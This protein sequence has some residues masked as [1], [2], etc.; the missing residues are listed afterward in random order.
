MRESARRLGLKMPFK[1]VFLR[2]F[3]DERELEI[4]ASNGAGA[5]R[6][7]Q[8][9]PIAAMS[10]GPGPKRQE[11]DLQVP[12]GVYRIDR[13]NPK[14]RFH[15]S[16]GLDYPNASDRRRSSARRLGGDIFIH[17]NRV[18]IG[19]MAMTDPVI[20]ELYPACFGAG[21]RRSISVHVFPCRMEGPRY[22]AL[23]R[24][25]PQHAAFWHELEPVYAAFQVGHRVPRVVIDGHGAYRI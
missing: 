23:L 6:L 2:A 8:T 22:A 11:G 7:V 16:M 25:F 4:W 19:C 24:Q 10:G 20:D 12:E 21:N 14:S 18:S 9:Y 15:L 3:K 5:M 13:F 17:G 1:R